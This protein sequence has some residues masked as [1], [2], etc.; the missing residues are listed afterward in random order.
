MMRS[1]IA[2]LLSASFTL[3]LLLAGGTVCAMPHGETASLTGHWETM[4]SAAMAGM[5]VSGPLD[6][7]APLVSDRESSSSDQPARPC[8]EPASR[9]PGHCAAPCSATFTL[10]A[11]VASRQTPHDPTRVLPTPTLEPPSRSESPEPPPPRA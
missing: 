9:V 8:D 4:E 7:A 3:Q 10:A 5:G 2:T 11:S 6:R 1:F